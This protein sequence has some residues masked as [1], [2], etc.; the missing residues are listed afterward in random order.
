MDRE[1]ARNFIGGR[2]ING[3]MLFRLVQPN[4]DPL[5]P[6]NVLIFGTGPLTGTPGPTARFT[7]TFLS[8]ATGL[9]GDANSGGYW[10][11]ELKY[12]GYD[13]V[14]LR[15][16]AEKPVYIEIRDEKIQIRDAADTLGLK[17]VGD[18]GVD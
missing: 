4:T 14:I 8:P 1:L 2:G 9:F 5:S 18:N 13:F 15:G 16:K 7:A 11:A 17:R 3:R 12:A 10:G 6:E